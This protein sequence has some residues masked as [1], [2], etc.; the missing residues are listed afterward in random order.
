MPRHTPKPG[1]PVRG[2][3]SGRPVMALLDLIGRRWVLRIIW[4]LR[5]GP[6]TFRALQD[7]CGGV[8]PSVLNQRLAEL[9]DTALIHS[10]SEQGYALTGLGRELLAQLAPLTLWAEKWA[11]ATSEP[12]ARKTR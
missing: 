2:S 7:A 12:T 4:E 10:E 5:S 8:S 11:K 9:H 3:R 1:Q 6:L